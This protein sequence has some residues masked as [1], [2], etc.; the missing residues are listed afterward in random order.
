MTRYT[1]LDPKVRKQEILT[2]AVKL[3]KRIGYNSIERDAVADLAKVSPPLVSKY[4]NTMS[5]LRT[6]VM[7]EAVRL[8]IP[9][10]VAQGLAVSCPVA[11]DAPI[12]LRKAAAATLAG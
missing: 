12:E 1:R 9:E 10:I 3:A 2:A 8:E 4:F 5:N 7:R 6:E 11:K